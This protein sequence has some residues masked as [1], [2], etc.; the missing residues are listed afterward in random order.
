MRT[1][2]RAVAIGVCALLVAGAQRV[3]P[4]PIVIVHATLLDGRGGPPA[5]DATLLI[6]GRVIEAVGAAGQVAVPKDAQVIDAT[7]KTVMPGLADLHV[8]FQGGWDGVSVDFLG[9]QRYFNALLYAGVTTVLDMGN[10]QPW[11]IQLRQ[12]VASGRVLGPRIYCVGAFVDGV[13]AAVPD[14]SYVVATTAQIP[15][16]VRRDKKAGVDLIKG[17]ANL[18]D[19]LMPRLAEEAAKVNLRVVVDQWDRNGAP[20]LAAYGIA[21]FAHLPFRPMPEADIR[22]LKDKGVF[23]L[24]TLATQESHARTRLADLAFLKEPLIADTAAPWFLAE[25]RAEAARTLSEKD[26]KEMEEE[27]VRFADS[28]TNLKKL[29]DA[30]VLIA[31]GTDAPYPGVFQGDGIHRELEL[32]V[33][34]GL[35]P[36]EAIRSATYDAARVMQAE[37]EWGSLEP[38]RRADVL[39]VAGHPAERISDTRKVE[40]VIREGRI[41]DRRVLRF[42]PKRDPEYRT[43]AGVDYFAIFD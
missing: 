16:I 22:V 13:D 17:Y 32:L 10:S 8:H 23:V 31:A 19:T 25:L 14:F 3:E 37:R 5:R 11:I 6:R 43:A 40:V 35:T 12:E 9:Y 42:D 34:S 29:F 2:T 33:Q 20:E 7:G 30:G 41:L 4:R 26:A 28:K 27:R 36:L 18:S 24:T 39:V 21:G 15:G 1:L 38:G